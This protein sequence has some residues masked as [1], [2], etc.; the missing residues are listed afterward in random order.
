MD[1]FLAGLVLPVG[2]DPEVGGDAGVVEELFGQGD[3]GL[4]PVVLDDPAADFTFAGTGVAGEER[5]S[6]EDMPMREPWRSLW[7]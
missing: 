2:E 1:L 4:Q 6:V 7:A 3:D 5:R